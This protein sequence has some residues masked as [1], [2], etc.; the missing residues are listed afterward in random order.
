M[1]KGSSIG[2]WILLLTLCFSAR[3]FSAVEGKDIAI[4][5]SG[6]SGSHSFEYNFKA[7]HHEIAELLKENNYK[8][9]NLFLFSEKE[10]ENDR[11]WNSRESSSWA[12]LRSF[13]KNMGSKTLKAKLDRA[14]ILIAGHAN[15]RDEEAMLHL[16]GKDISLKTMQQWVKEIHAK[17]KVIIIM[18][19]QG[20]SWI[21]AMAGEGVVTV[22]GNVSREFDVLPVIFMQFLTEGLAGN[23]NVMSDEV[24]NQDKSDSMKSL[25]DIFVETQIKTQ[26]WYQTNNLQATEIGAVDGDG[27]GIG[28]SMIESLHQEQPSVTTYAVQIEQTPDALSAEKIQ[29]RFVRGE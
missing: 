23:F 19:P 11:E 8:R 24:E 3:A 25:K 29:F 27:D 17:E 9:Q 1:S 10:S 18:T 20:E 21:E 12:N 14:F 5:V 16:P 26:E 7:L 6:I 22:V 4:V 13:F 15:G 2:L 28:S